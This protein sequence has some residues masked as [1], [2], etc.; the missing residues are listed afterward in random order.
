MALIPPQKTGKIT[1]VPVV[2][3]NHR[4]VC[5]NEFAS[6]IVKRLHGAVTI[7]KG[8]NPALIMSIPILCRTKNSNKTPIQYATAIFTGV[9]ILFPFS[10]RAADDGEYF[11]T[12]QRGIVSII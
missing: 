5:D 8:M 12:R 2:D 9:C 6:A 1:K 4:G 11:T 3:I 10:E 7:A